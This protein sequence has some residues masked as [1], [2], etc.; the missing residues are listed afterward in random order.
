MT[1]LE[2]DIITALIDDRLNDL[3]IIDEEA[4]DI[5]ALENLKVRLLNTGEE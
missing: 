4:E 2:I 1:P 5:A 3:G